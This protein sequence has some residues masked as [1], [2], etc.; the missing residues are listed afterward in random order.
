MYAL[1]L[2]YKIEI[3]TTHRFTDKLSLE[4]QFNNRVNFHK[5]FLKLS[6]FAKKLTVPKIIA[7]IIW[8]RNPHK[9][10]TAKTFPFACS[11]SFFSVETG[12]IT[13]WRSLNFN[14]RYFLYQWS[15]NISQR[16]NGRP[17]SCTNKEQMI[18]IQLHT[19]SSPARWN[20]SHREP[21]IA[22]L[23]ARSEPL[24][25][26]FRTQHLQ[27]RRD[28][29]TLESNQLEERMFSVENSEATTKFSQS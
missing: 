29:F 26:R 22:Y 21:S 24:D 9:K 2:Y 8:Y 4:W 11:G 28:L 20:G 14:V 25:V 1:D 13:F 16:S 18:Y 6:K 3:V 17:Y 23:S 12:K 27:E 15:V 7:F 5:T 10:S 19:H